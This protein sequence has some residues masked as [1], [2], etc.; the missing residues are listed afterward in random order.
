[1]SWPNRWPS[2]PRRTFSGS[3]PPAAPREELLGGIANRSIKSG[4]G[5][6]PNQFARRTPVQPGLLPFGFDPLL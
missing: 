4:I 3:V 5:M 1:M 2:V 6:K